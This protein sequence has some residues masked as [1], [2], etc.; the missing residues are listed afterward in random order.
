M[1]LDLCDPSCDPINVLQT[2]LDEDGT[3]FHVPKML[4]WFKRRY[5][6]KNNEELRNIV[7]LWMII[8]IEIG[9]LE[10]TGKYAE[11]H[12]YYNLTRKWSQI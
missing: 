8:W 10:K 1:N 11:N 9:C 5:P 2:Y 4:S 3:Y 6:E 7:D 12:E